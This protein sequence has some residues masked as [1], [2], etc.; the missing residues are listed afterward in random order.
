MP[1]TRRQ[2]LK[3]LTAATFATTALGR[4][5]A[6]AADAPVVV[7]SKV[8]TEGSV[9]GKIIVQVLTANRIPVTDKV[10]FGT[11]DVIRKAITAKEIDLYP[12]YTGNGE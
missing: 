12:E 4:I 10:G 11:T 2:A 1:L 7:A 9:L 3:T 8:D 6:F 5:P